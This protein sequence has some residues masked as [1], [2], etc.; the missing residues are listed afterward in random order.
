LSYEQRNQVLEARGMKRNVST[1][2]MV[3]SQGTTVAHDDG[4]RGQLPRSL[5]EKFCTSM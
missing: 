3:V 4:I 2:G 1:V 5:R